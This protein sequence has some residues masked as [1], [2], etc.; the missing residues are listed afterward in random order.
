MVLGQSTEDLGQQ[1]QTT[2]AGEDE[3]SSRGSRRS[4]R[5]HLHKLPAAAG[6]AV[7]AERQLLASSSMAT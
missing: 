2:R 6:K 7:G 5:R 3:E 4:S 1:S